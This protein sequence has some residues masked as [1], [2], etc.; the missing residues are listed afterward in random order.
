MAVRSAFALGLH[1]AES[2][3]AV[4]V[5]EREIRRSLWKTLVILDRFLSAS[6]G[7]PTAIN[8]E[9]CSE[10]LLDPSGVPVDSEAQDAG[11]IVVHVEGL[12]AVVRSS[13]AIGII[14]KLV[15]S[16]R[17]V[18]TALAHSIA[19]SNRNWSAKLH[20]E[21]N[22][23]RAHKPLTAGHGIALLHT[24]LFQSHTTLLLTRPFFLFLIYRTQDAQARGDPSFGRNS[25]SR[26]EKF[27]RACV[28]ASNN[29]IHVA[30]RAFL[31]NYLSRRNP[32][33][34]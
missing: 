32:F 3:P 17:K 27:S 33:V 28:E 34:L 21:L 10:S 18:T 7:R 20:T 14:L 13:Q 5:L 31:G 16:E 11:D 23:R 26:L 1:R 9:D 12:N 2:L 15:Y 30:H 19:E 29:S 4:P 24:N 22:W 8:E 6:L 25:R